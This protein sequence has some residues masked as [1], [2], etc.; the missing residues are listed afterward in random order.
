MRNLLKFSLPFILV[1]PFV[2]YYYSVFLSSISPKLVVLITLPPSKYKV[3]MMDDRVPSF[4][5][6]TFDGQ[7]PYA[8]GDRAQATVINSLQLVKKC[9]EDPS[10]I[11][12]DVGGF[13]GNNINK[14]II[15]RIVYLQ[16]V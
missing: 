9:K 13:L 2:Y 8:D 10:F 15:S 3:V 11:V 5:L 16:L 7:Q 12:I 1:T 14:K 6:A 4:K